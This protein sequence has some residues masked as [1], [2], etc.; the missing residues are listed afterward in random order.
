MHLDTTPL[1]AIDAAMYDNGKWCGKTVAIT[2]T[3]T[4]K[5]INALVADECPGCASS[6]SLDL[7][8]GA[9]DQLGTEEEGTF[10]ITWQFV[11]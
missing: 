8:T 11:N 7:S 1:V 5:T 4:G 9:Y 2:R 6:G 10:P 3:S